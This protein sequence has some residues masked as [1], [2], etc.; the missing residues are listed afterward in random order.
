MPALHPFDEMKRWVGFTDADV[1]RLRDFLPIA[2]R[3]IPAII[4][5]FYT[6]VLESDGARSVL[7]DERQVER[8][9][10]T[11]KVWLTEALAGPHDSAYFERRERIGKRHVEVGLPSRYMF[12]AMNVAQADL[13]DIAHAETEEPLTAELCRSIQRLMTLDLAIMTGTYVVG[14]ERAQLQSLQD[15]LVRHLRISVMLIAPDGIVH[16]ATQAAGAGVPGDPIGQ[17]WRDV[18]PAGLRAAASLDR[19]V[20]RAIQTGHEVTLP[21]VEVPTEGRTQTY[22]IHI[23]PLAHDFASFLLQI[24]EI[25]DVVD[26]EARLQRSEALAQIGGLSAA[27]A[28]ELRNPLAGI[29]GAIQVIGR[30]LP[31]DAPYRPIMAKVDDEV[32]RLNGLVTDLLAFARPPTARNSAMSLAGAAEGAAELVKADWPRVNFEIDGSGDAYADPDLVRQI[33]LNLLNN[34]AQAVLGQGR[35]QI[36]VRDGLVRVEDDGP[37]VPEGIRATVFDPFFTTKTRGTGLGLA[38]SRRAARAMG[39]DLALGE[40]SPLGGATFLLLLSPRERPEDTLLPDTE[41]LG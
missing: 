20:E 28:H 11:L 30:A 10:V 6:K 21:R 37:G 35:V 32:R 31:P 5:H 23:V 1:R 17:P 22:R 3:H 26:L 2:E 7:E 38:I 18:V 4:D 13:C 8:L 40:A 36:R 19:H 15:V 33:L 27:V 29:S 12:T 41:A 24:D 14:R 16:A 34:A 9:K 25:T 39:G